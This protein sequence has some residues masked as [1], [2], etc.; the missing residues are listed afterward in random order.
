LE[1]FARKYVCIKRE[2]LIITYGAAIDAGG[3]Y[4]STEEKLL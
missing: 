1:K 4:I 3:E 2:I